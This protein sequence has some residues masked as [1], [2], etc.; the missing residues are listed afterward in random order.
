[1][2]VNVIL[3]CISH[4]HYRPLGYLPIVRQVSV[5][6]IRGRRRRTHKESSTETAAL[7]YEMDNKKNKVSK[8]VKNASLDLEE[9]SHFFFLFLK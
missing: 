5:Q 9:L 7:K 3:H 6:S 1:M 4:H 2:R 8:T